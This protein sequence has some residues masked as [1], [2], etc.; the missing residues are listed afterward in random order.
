M[1]TELNIK[2]VL[3]MERINDK[4]LNKIIYRAEVDRTR[5]RL[6]LRQDGLQE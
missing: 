6:N 2:E 1:F 5:E 3:D 4:R